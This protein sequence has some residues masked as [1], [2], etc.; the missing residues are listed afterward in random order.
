M[1]IRTYRWNQTPLVGPRSLVISQLHTCEGTSARSSGLTLAGRTSSTTGMR[2]SKVPSFSML[3]KSEVLVHLIKRKFW[4]LLF[5]G[6]VVEGGFGDV[7]NS[8]MNC[9]DQG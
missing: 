4:L 2:Y 3:T 7:A 5:V 1:S 6:L 8:V 9:S